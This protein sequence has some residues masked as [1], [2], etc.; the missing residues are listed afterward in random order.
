MAS[1]LLPQWRSAVPPSHRYVLRR[2]GPFLR[3]RNGVL[4]TVIF[5]AFTLIG[6]ICYVAFTSQGSRLIRS[7]DWHGFPRARPN[8]PQRVHVDP[9]VSPSATHA[10]PS[11]TSSPE[12]PSPPLATAEPTLEHI[13]DI[14]ASTRGFFSRDYSLHLGWNNVCMTGI[15][16]AR[17]TE[18]PFIDAVYHRCCLP[19]S[20]I[21]QSHLGYSFI[22]LHS[23]VRV[24]AVRVF[25]CSTS[26]TVSLQRL[27]T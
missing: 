22:Y 18:N 19:S 12:P 8:Y 1:E 4:K 20:R 9:S 10:Y 24:P 26:A 27:V 6:L 3:T 13:R 21:A 16:S 17:R 15:T 5:S 25:L 11:P 14:V 2:C 23:R 7:S